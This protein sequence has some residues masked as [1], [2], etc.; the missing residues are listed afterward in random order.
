MGNDSQTTDSVRHLA[1]VLLKDL[2]NR[3]HPP[4][5]SPSKLQYLS[6]VKTGAWNR[7]ITL[8]PFVFFASFLDPRTKNSTKKVLN[9][10]N[11][12]ALVDDILE[13]MVKV[14]ESNQQ[15]AG[16]SNT[17]H[18]NN[19]CSQS[20]KKRKGNAERGS[21]YNNNFTTDDS[22]D[23]NEEDGEDEEDTEEQSINSVHN[24]CKLELSNV[25]TDANAQQDLKD[26]NTNEFNDCLLWW[27][28]QHANQF[29]G[30]LAKLARKYLSIPATSAASERI[31]SRASNILTIRRAKLSD[32]IAGNIM[33]I[34]ENEKILFEHYES[35]TGDDVT[36]LIF[37]TCTT[38]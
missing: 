26:E 6:K 12:R 24:R 16:E 23:E 7:Y 38:F 32:A 25:M 9:D 17:Q 11:Y 31:W 22:D 8:H 30:V 13:E 28:L 19:S 3:Y 35:L 21:I 5:D 2:D 34:K 1:K 33:F 27:K 4:K 37:P 29:P 10:D 20:A 36:Q 14:E 18:N 15:H